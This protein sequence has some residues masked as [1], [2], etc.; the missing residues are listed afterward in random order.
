MEEHV[1]AQRRASTELLGAASRDKHAQAELLDKNLAAFEALL[2]QKDASLESAGAKLAD[3]RGELERRGH[4]V[5]E[6]G[7]F[8]GSHHADDP[9][10]P[11]AKNRDFFP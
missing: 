4:E 8:F 7:D 6:Q 5:A 11:Q 3:T 1:R 9:I 10:A 2:A